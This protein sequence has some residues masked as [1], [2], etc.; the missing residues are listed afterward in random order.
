MKPLVCFISIS[1]A[2]IVCSA[3][4]SAD[5]TKSDFIKIR[6]TSPWSSKWIEDTIEQIKHN[7]GKST[8]FYI[9][10]SASEGCPSTWV[11][12][13]NTYNRQQ[14][15][16][17]LSNHLKALVKEKLAA[18]PKSTINKCSKLELVIDGGKITSSEKN[19]RYLF[20]QTGSV[21]FIPKGHKKGRV[22]NALIESDGRK[23]GAVYNM[24]LEKF[25]DFKYR[26]SKATLDCV[27]GKGSAIYNITN[28][29]TGDFKVYGKIG[30]TSFL[31]SNISPKQLRIQFPH[32]VK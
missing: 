17:E 10:V 1:L 20:V 30:D 11:G 14:A 3:V 13:R 5:Y 28:S 22:V 31:S 6:T 9:G 7:P 16:T 23:K 24:N 27:I 4:F 12:R 2:S 32:L 25:C 21:V 19:K 15:I 18:F 8:G 29:R 26:K